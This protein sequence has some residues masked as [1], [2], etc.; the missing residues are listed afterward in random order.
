MVPADLGDKAALA[1]VEAVLRG[2]PSIAMLVNNAGVASRAPL[3][4]ADVDEMEAMI[5][6]NVTA[7]TRLTYAVAPAFV[8][9]STGTIINI[10]SVVGI[11]PER[12]N[13]VYGASK[14]FVLALSHSLH[15]ELADKGVRVQAVLP[16]ATATDIWEKSGLHYSKLP[17]GT[18][19]S[20]EDMVDAALAGLDQGEV[21][22]IP[23]LQDGDRLDPLRGGA[24]RA[25]AE[26]RQFR[27]GAPIPRSRTRS[28]DRGLK[29]RSIGPRE[30]RLTR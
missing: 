16:A 24:P 18:V 2:D 14:A 19:M 17:A 27:P 26:V 11:A 10:A 6:L 30:P 4:D 15:H 13:G 1:K 29:S 5:T 8:A 9:R 3:L 20:T 28:A 21:V 25:R 22:T 23:S 12:L 7:L